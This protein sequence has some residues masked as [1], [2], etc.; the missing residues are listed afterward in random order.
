M[1]ELTFL[2]WQAPLLPQAAEWLAARFREGNRIDLS[3]ALLVVPGA[4]AG[5]RLMELLAQSAGQWRVRERWLRSQT[6]VE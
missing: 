2:H 3:E 5:R 1:A 6:D 4:R